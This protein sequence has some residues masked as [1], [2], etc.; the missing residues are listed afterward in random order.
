MRKAL[1]WV[2]VWLAVAAGQVSA[3]RWHK[4]WDA[5]S[6]FSPRPH[7][8]IGVYLFFL[9]GHD[10]GVEGIWRQ[11]GNLNLGVR[12]G[13]AEDLVKVGAEFYGPIRIEAPLQLAWQLGVGAG[14]GDDVTM[15]RVPFGVSLGG[16]LGS[17][18]TLQITPYVYPRVALDLY[19]FD[20]GDDEE[21][22]TEVNFDVDLGADI[23]LSPAWS[24]KVGATVGESEA[25][26]LGLA[27]RMQRR[28]VVR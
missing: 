19:A 24:L 6:F 21:T 18:G 15:L 23:R 14:F 11:T 3:Q 28:V 27:Y 16:T 8:D 4:P 2:G 5:P 20:V 22:D 1:L 17:P 26:G 12:V 7:D 9:D 13:V 10:A 25:F